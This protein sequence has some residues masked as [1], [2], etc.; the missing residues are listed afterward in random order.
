[1]VALIGEFAESPGSGDVTV[2]QRRTVVGSSGVSSRSG[3]GAL[4]ITRRGRCVVGAALAVLTAAVGWLPVARAS[5]SSP[6]PR[7]VTVS[8]GQTLSEIAVT[9]LPHVSVDNGIVAIRIAN[10]MSSA[11]IHAGQ[12]LVIPT[13]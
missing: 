10:R 6:A 11:Q 12:R 4:R 5:G 2:R 7:T 8:T 1:M 9:H 13:P 3:P